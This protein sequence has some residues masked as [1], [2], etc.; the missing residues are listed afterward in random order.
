M[1]V[2]YHSSQV[3]TDFS[4]IKDRFSQK[5]EYLSCVDLY[6]VGHMTIG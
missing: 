3:E 5:V 6:L 2:S 1:Y 4:T